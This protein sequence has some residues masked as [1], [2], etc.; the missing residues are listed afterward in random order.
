[1]PNLYRGWVRQPFRNYIPSEI[2]GLTTSELEM[3]LR[4]QA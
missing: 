3:L 1:M 4:E 2:S